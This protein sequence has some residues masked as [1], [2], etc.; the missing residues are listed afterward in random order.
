ME[1]NKISF[2]YWLSV[3]GFGLAIIATGLFHETHYAVIAIAFALMA[4]ATK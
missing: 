1:K 2:L 3:L 4:N